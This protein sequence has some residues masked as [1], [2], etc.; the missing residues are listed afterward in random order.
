MYFESLW[1]LA[2]LAHKLA[3]PPRRRHVSARTAALLR[4][5]VQDKEGRSARQGLTSTQPFRL[6]G[7]NLLVLVA[8][9]PKGRG[10]G[11]IARYPGAVRTC[12]SAI[13]HFHLEADFIGLTALL[14]CPFVSV[15]QLVLPYLHR[16]FAILV[17]AFLF[18]VHCGDCNFVSLRLKPMWRAAAEA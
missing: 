2:S 10:S 7:K 9:E 17:H 11:A 14:A 13:G 6:A 1:D 5:R 8:F 16:R 12:G 18:Q 4:A 3:R 15:F